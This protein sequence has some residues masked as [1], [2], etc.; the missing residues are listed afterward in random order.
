MQHLSDIMGLAV[1]A[2]PLVR[3]R[4]LAKKGILLSVALLLLIA[5]LLATRLNLD[6]TLSDFSIGL[7]F[8]FLLYS[9]LSVSGENHLPANRSKVR[10]GIGFFARFSYTLYVVHFPLLVFTRA[11]SLSIGQANWQPDPRHI[12]LGM[13]LLLVVLLYAWAVSALTEAH[14]DRVRRIVWDGYARSARH[15]RNLRLSGSTGTGS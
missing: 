2:V 10:S 12:G 7:A 3:T 11:W 1:L 9:I 14:T 6:P 8:A 13:G 15:L 4:R 5:S